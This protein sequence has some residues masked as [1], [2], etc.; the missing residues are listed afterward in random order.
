MAKVEQRF[1]S[2]KVCLMCGKRDTTS[3][4]RPRSLKRT[5]KI[6]KPNFQKRWGFEFC[7]NCYRTLKKRGF[8]V[9]QFRESAPAS[10]P[11]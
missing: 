10:K 1:K 8:D 7:Q 11:S 2:A 6:V 4:N 9:K 5:L 3:L